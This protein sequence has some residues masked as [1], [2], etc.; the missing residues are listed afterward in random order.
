MSQEN[1]ELTRRG[2]QAFNDRDLDALLAMLEDDVEIVPILAAME[3]GYRGHDGVRRWL[4]SV[5]KPPPPFRTKVIETLDDARVVVEG[6]IEALEV[7][8]LFEVRD[9][10]VA[11]VSSYATDRTMLEHLGRI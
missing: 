1:V 2:V 7:V 10:K 6:A 9:G 11:S 3:G 4:V 5:G 8:A